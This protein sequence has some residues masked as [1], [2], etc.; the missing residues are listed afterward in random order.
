M[1]ESAAPSSA[2]APRHMRKR[3]SFHRPSSDASRWHMS[4]EAV[5]RSVTTIAAW[6]DLQCV[7]HLSRVRWGDYKRVVC[8]HCNTGSEHYWS[9]KEL[10]WKCQHCGKRFSVTS[11]GVRQQTLTPAK[12]L[13]R[14]PPVGGRRLRAACTGTAQNAEARRLQHEL[15]AHQQAA[16]GIASRVQY[17]AGQW[18]RRNGRRRLRVDEPARSGAGHK[19][20]RS[21]TPKNVWRQSSCCRLGACAIELCEVAAHAATKALGTDGTF[22][23]RHRLDAAGK[24]APCRR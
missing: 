20:S 19:R 13:E 16:R 18:R 4:K 22:P 9:A 23:D 11:N 8:P 10:R 2:P 1:T 6:T 7:R 21:M 24:A 15:H 17:R 3:S 12:A 5:D 14:H